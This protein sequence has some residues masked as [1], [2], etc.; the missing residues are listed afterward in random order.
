M[1]LFNTPIQKFIFPT[2]DP[3]ELKLF[4]FNYFTVNFMSSEAEFKFKPRL[5]YG[6]FHLKNC[7][8]CYKFEAGA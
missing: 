8:Q 3:S 5:K 2:T 4:N 7:I 1:Y 6:W